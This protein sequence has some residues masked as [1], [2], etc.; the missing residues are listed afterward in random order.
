MLNIKKL[1]LLSQKLFGLL[2]NWEDPGF[3]LIRSVG[4]N[5]Q[6]NLLGVG[7]S[8]KYKISKISFHSKGH[9]NLIIYLNFIH[10]S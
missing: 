9:F 8:L 10:R 2:D 6:A 4:S 5:T 7:V 1:N 3:T